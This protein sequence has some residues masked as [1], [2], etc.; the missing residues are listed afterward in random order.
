MKITKHEIINIIKKTTTDVDVDSLD[1]DSILS[2]N[3]VDSLDMANILLQIEENYGVK[4]PGKDSE[5]LFSIN[6][7]EKYVSDN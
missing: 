2:E 5:K 6:A 4:I 3:G 7:I 1:H